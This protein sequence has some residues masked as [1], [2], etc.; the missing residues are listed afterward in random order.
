MIRAVVCILSG[1]L[2]LVL[3]LGA[4]PASAG[5]VMGTGAMGG[6]GRTSHC[7]LLVQA[8]PFPFVDMAGAVVTN[9]SVDQSAA[10]VK[11]GA[12]SMYRDAA[13]DYV[14]VPFSAA[15]SHAGNFCESQW[16]R[17]AALGVYLVNQ[18]GAAGQR[19]RRLFT[20]AT[21]AVD[22]D[23]LDSADATFIDL[24][25]PAGTVVVDTWA[26]LEVCRAGSAAS[27]FVGGA[28]VVSD[29]TATG[30]VNTTNSALF[31]GRVASGSIGYYDAWMI[32]SG[33]WVWTR[34]HTP[35]NRRW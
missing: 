5:L 27:L 33:G 14:S 19:A 8:A 26:H 22:V 20:T 34:A 6:Q 30:T 2:G 23:Y 1:L 13:T 11:F 25:S 16:V 15:Y 10:Q 31:L 32:T 4:G 29:A 28:P 3:L 24:T 18:Y 35:P 7:K 21:G 12:A 9:V 17:V